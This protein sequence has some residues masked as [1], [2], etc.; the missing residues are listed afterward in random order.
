MSTVAWNLR[1]TVTCAA[2][3]HDTPSASRLP[4]RRPASSESANMTTMPANATRHR[5]P[6]ARRHRLA[7]H[8]PAGERGEERRHAHQHERVGDGRARER[9]DEEEERAGEEQART[10]GRA[11]RRRRTACGIRA[12]VHHEQ[13]AGDEQRHEHAAPEHDLPGVGDRQLAHE[14]AAGRPADRGD[15][16]D[17]DRAAVRAGGRGGSFGVRLKHRDRGGSIGTAVSEPPLAVNRKV[18]ARRAGCP[19]VRSPRRRGR[20]ISTCAMPSSS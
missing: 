2:K 18:N 13:H 12:P 16:H 4:T 3:Q 7:Q 9:A 20:S 19:R 8:Q 17:Q 11:C 1:S 5:E 6:G 14:D 15:D 10:A